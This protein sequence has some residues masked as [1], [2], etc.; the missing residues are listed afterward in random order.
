MVI[1]LQLMVVPT[2]S[3]EAQ[4]NT[5]WI[6]RSSTQGVC[7]R[8]WESI[9][10]VPGRGTRTLGQF[11]KGYSVIGPLPLIEG[12][13]ALYRV[14]YPPGHLKEQCLYALWTQLVQ[15]ED[16]ISGKVTIGG[17]ISQGLIGHKITQY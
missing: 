17:R 8:G 11:V 14:K 15:T 10:Q 6:R 3:L 16:N 5:S 1:I 13:S 4:I 7:V 9:T 2:C 12:Q